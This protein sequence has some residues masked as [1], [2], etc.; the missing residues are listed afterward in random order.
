MK[1]IFVALALSA[2]PLFAAAAPGGKP[3][4][5]LFAPVTRADENLDF[6]SKVPP[7]TAIVPVAPA[8]Y[9]NDPAICVPS[10]VAV[11]ENDGEEFELEYKLSVGRA[12][13]EFKTAARDVCK[14]KL[15]DKRLVV[16]FPF[17]LG[18]MFEDSDEYGDYEIRFEAKNLKTGETAK[19]STPLRLERWERPGPIRGAR[20][21]NEAV[22]AYNGS[23]DPKTAYA[24]FTS[25]D[26]NFADGDGNFAYAMFGF[27]KT[28][29]SRHKF[30]LAEAER[31]FPNAGKIQRR[32]SIQLFELLGEGY[33]LKGLDKAET[34]LRDSMWNVATSLPRTDGTPGSGAALD[35]LWGEFFAGGS[36]GPIE[37]IIACA[38]KNSGDCA[39]VS[40]LVSAGK[41]LRPEMDDRRAL[42]GLTAIS[43]CWS[44]LSNSR[45]NPL[46]KKYI[47]HTLGTLPKE[48]IKAFDTAVKATKAYLSEARQAES[49]RM[50]KSP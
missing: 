32:N 11:A 31:E 3:P 38:V 12:G 7:N 22:I 44:L 40:E 21:L 34:A 33:R 43:A 27:M 29:F 19:T 49:R 18:F 16:N 4:M 15:A 36:C 20:E 42:S 50:G 41:P 30:L 48:D 23:F 35:M 45:R 1:R 5:R 37:K 17:A 9:K 28:V 25:P 2:L 26:M 47:A 10:A 14:G 24:I 6:L 39:R 13:G 46:A 8:L